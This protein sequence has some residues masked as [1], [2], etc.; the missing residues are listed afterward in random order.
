LEG[1]MGRRFGPIISPGITAYFQSFNRNKKS[2]AINL[3]KAT[4]REILYKLI[5]KADVFSENFQR[6]VAEKLGLGYEDLSRINPKIVYFSGSGFG[7]KGPLSKNLAFDGVGQAMAGILSTMWSPSGQPP[8]VVGVPI[9]DQTGGYLGALGIVLALLHRE[10]TGE[11]QVVDVSLLG[12]GIG[13]ANWLLQAFLI[14]GISI[15]PKTRA[16]ISSIA[17]SST[18]LTKDGKP[19][20]IQIVSDTL[21]AGLK[22]LGLES[23][24]DDPR[25][26]MEEVNKHSEQIVMILDKAF[27]KKNREDWLH[28]FA[29]AGVVAVPVLNFEEV[30]KH[31]QVLM[32]EYIVE[33]EDTKGKSMKILGSPIKFSKTPARLG[34]A[35]ELGEHTESVLFELAGY[36][37]TEIAD[38]KKIG[39]V[40]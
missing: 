34:V 33:I 7:L 5:E 16:R 6:G 27:Q 31:P 17:I 19:I 13:L 23:L 3:K 10:R 26:K 22:V 25:F 8:P 1:E 28:A 21:E 35:P 18:H 36:S 11:G 39:V 15:R 2:I 32:N 29:A 12:T 4:G 38:L 40:G 9:C 14:Q 30:S 37:K 20:L 24:L